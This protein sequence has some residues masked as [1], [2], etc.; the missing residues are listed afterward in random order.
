MLFEHGSDE[1]INPIQG[2]PI[3]GDH[4]WEEVVGSKKRP[5]SLLPKICHSCPAILTIIKL[6]TVITDPK[7]IQKN[8]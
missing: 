8:I 3:Q 5:P 4:R 1:S 6:G 2:R 7:K